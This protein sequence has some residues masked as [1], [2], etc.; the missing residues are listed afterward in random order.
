MGR[1]AGRR[2]AETRPRPRPSSPLPDV[3]GSLSPVRGR[4]ILPV[5][6]TDR[7]TARRL[8]PKI[9]DHIQD[10]A[11][12]ARAAARRSSRESARR[13]A[14]CTSRSGEPASRIV[15]IDRG[16]PF[17][18]GRAADRTAPA[19]AGPTG[20]AAAVGPRTASSAISRLGATDFD[21]IDDLG[22]DRRS[23]GP[24]CARRWRSRPAKCA[25]TAGSRARS[26]IRTRPA[27]SAKRWRA[28]RSRCWFPCHRVVDASGA[29]HHYGYGLE[30]KAR[31][32]SM[33]G[34]APPR[35]QG[36]CARHRKV[37]RSANQLLRM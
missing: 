19:P 6:L 26:A 21:R 10:R 24:R 16:E 2:R 13:S 33:E 29:L 30:L 28:T 12:R 15:G 27:P 35:A 11:R 17:D 32:L 22:S 7:R 31:I 36:A 3:P 25:P 8:V 5:V 37:E 34:Y 4:R 20:R 18:G 23:S 14:T 1:D 9:L